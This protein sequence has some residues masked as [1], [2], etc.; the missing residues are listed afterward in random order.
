MARFMRGR[1]DACVP[2]PSAAGTIDEPDGW[3][4]SEGSTILGFDPAM[5]LLRSVG[6]GVAQ[7][8]MY[9]ATDDAERPPAFA[10]PYVVKLADVAHRTDHGAVRAG[11]GL[12][13]LPAAVAHLRDLAES[14]QLPTDV[15]VQA[16]VAG[17]GEVFAGLVGQSELGPLVAF[18]VGGIFVEVVDRVGGRLAPIGEGDAQELLEEFTDLGVFTGFRGGRPWD[19]AELADLV[20]KLGRLV[21]GARRWLHEMD[22]NPLILTDGGPLAVDAL[23]YRSS[24]NTC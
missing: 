13:D 21:A 9:K 19:R 7:Y 12:D 15:V 11:I 14:K 8:E 24:A 22:V 5:R 20:I 6:I 18:G 1:D 10:G 2:D 4:E 17:H 3:I 16:M 23:C